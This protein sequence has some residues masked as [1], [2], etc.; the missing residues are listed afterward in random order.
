MSLS[1]AIQI[2]MVQ[3]T[4]APVAHVTVVAFGAKLMPLA[5]QLLVIHEIQGT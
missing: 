5:V 3:L 1:I 4:M 2:Q